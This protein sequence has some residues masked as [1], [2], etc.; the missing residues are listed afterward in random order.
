MR[1][2]AKRG[3]FQESLDCGVRLIEVIGRQLNEELTGLR[4]RAQDE[5]RRLTGE[6]DALRKR[7]GG[8]A[9]MEDLQKRLAEVSG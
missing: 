8:Q 4:N 9:H 2:L 7:G 5:I 1:T 3:I 6:I